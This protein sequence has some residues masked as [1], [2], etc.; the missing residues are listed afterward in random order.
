MKSSLV[1]Q[2]PPFIAIGIGIMEFSGLGFGWMWGHYE[3]T[4]FFIGW[5]QAALLPTGWAVNCECEAIRGLD[6]RWFCF[7]ETSRLFWSVGWWSIS[8]EKFAGGVIA[9]SNVL[10]WLRLSWSISRD[11]ATAGILSGIWVH[12]ACTPTPL[13]FRAGGKR[14][15]MYFCLPY[16]P[17]LMLLTLNWFITSEELWTGMMPWPGVLT[18]RRCSPNYRDDVKYIRK[19]CEGFFQAQQDWWIFSVYLFVDNYVLVCLGPV[20]WRW[21][22]RNVRVPAFKLEAR[23]CHVHRRSLLKVKIYNFFLWWVYLTYI[24]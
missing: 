15:L 11:F 21:G 12:L 9:V 16:R 2:I 8:L 7:H 4:V 1:V 6:Q 18:T 22:P 10:Y 17:L 19:Y 5:E 24:E 23:W 3:Q 13:G 20:N 14:L